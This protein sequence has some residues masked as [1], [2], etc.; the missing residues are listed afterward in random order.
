MGVK[1]LSLTHSHPFSITPTHDR[2]RT[3]KNEMIF[4]AIQWT[5]QSVPIAS[6]IQS[7]SILKR[8]CARMLI[9]R[10]SHLFHALCIIHYNVLFTTF[11][12]YMFLFSLSSW[13]W[14]DESKY[15]KI[16]KTKT[17]KNISGA[18]FCIVRNSLWEEKKSNTLMLSLVIVCR[19][20]NILFWLSQKKMYVEPF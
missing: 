9:P 12:S 6:A 2:P 18:C 3:R 15:K 13:C 11:S 7:K 4:K 1:R 20:R 10:S 5:W 14:S 16:T 19:L 8:H 17:R